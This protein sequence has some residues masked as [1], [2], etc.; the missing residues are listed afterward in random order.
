MGNM[1]THPPSEEADGCIYYSLNSANDLEVGCDIHKL[2]SSTPWSIFPLPS[3]RASTD[4]DPLPGTA[5]QII[6]KKSEPSGLLSVF[7]CC[8]FPLTFTV[9]DVPGNLLPSKH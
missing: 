7:G 1:Y 2:P 6:L 5:T 8:R 9:S 3:A 4:Q